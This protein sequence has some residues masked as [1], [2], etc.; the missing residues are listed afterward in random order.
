MADARAGVDVVGAKGRAHQLLD[1]EGLFVGAAGRRD[2]ADG[3]ATVLGLDA[4]E[5]R[6]RVVDGLVPAHFGPVVGDALADERLGDAVL[7][8]GITIGEASLHA[9]MAL[10]RATIA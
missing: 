10:V 2:A 1:Q 7:V 3:V 9:G 8:G 6:S 4:L 5:L